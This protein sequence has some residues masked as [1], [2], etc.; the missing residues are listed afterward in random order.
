MYDSAFIEELASSAP[1]PG[2]GGASAHAGAVA[3]ALASMVG[4]LTIGKPKYADVEAEIL[5]SLGRLSVLRSRLLSLVDEDA[6]A[7]EPLA[8][9]YGMPKSTPEEVAA[10]ERAMQAA[11]IPAC[12]VPLDIMGACLDVLCECEL[13]AECGS[14]LAVSDAGACAAIAKGAL[15]AASMNVWVNVKSISD[16]GIAEG[17]RTRADSLLEE[18]CAKADGIVRNVLGDLEA[19]EAA[20]LLDGKEIR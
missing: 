1:V 4:E 18:G 8:A 19:D 2:G 5:G 16:D 11:L 9:A 6:D 7:F 3:A 15:V 14:R 17:F 10:K 12:E 20:A 13:M